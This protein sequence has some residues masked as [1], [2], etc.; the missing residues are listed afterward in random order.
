MR[1]AMWNS[2]ILG[3]LW[4]LVVIIGFLYERHRSK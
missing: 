3:V 1:Y 4:I 2:L